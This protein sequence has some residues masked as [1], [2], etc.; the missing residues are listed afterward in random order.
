MGPTTKCVG[1]VFKRWGKLWGWCCQD[2]FIY[3]LK[4]PEQQFCYV[5]ERFWDPTPFDKHEYQRIQPFIDKQIDFP[6]YKAHYERYKEGL[7][8]IVELHDPLSHPAKL[9][10]GCGL[11]TL[12]AIAKEALD[13]PAQ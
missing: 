7:E 4:T 8:R 6:H 1:T 5:C 10:E 11:C 13:V 2:G 3:E 9:P 12:R